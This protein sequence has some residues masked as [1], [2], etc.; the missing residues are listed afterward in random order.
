M[1]KIAEVSQKCKG[2]DKRLR[3]PCFP[4]IL[5]L[6]WQLRG[7]STSL[8]SPHIHFYTDFKSSLN[9]SALLMSQV[10]SIGMPYGLMQKAMMR[11]LNP[12]VGCPL[13]S[14]MPRATTAIKNAKMESKV[15][16]IKHT[17]WKNSTRTVS[18]R[19]T[20]KSSILNNIL[21]DIPPSS[22]S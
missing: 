11:Y 4:M 20:G 17:N 19:V 22:T 13:K 2:R 8:L 15:V 14:S 18:T 3:R 5:L 7:E 9:A 10:A 16:P 1:K 21:M 6:R 12:S